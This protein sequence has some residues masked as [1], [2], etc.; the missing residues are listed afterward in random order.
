MESIYYD[1][2]EVEEDKDEE[3][4]MGNMGT[5]TYDHITSKW[6]G[7]ESINVLKTYFNEQIFPR[8]KTSLFVSY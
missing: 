3:V 5:T 2:I 4:Y 7:S 8:G 6:Y 1:V